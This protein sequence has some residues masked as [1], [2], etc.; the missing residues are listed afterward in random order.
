MQI[1]PFALIA[2]CCCLFLPFFTKASPWVG[3]VDKQL[4]YDLQTLVEWG[5]LD[6]T[7]NT[8]PVPWRGISSQVD[9]LSIDAMPYRPRQAL[10]RLKH[11]LS[12]QKQAKA[13]QYLMLQGASDDVRFR[14]LDDGVDSTGK[15]TLLTELY[16]GPWSA[17]VSVNYS[18][19][20]EKN[21]DNSFLAYQFGNWNLRLGS[22]EQF[23]G[24]AQ[25]SSLILSNNSRP[26]KALA[27]SRSSTAAPEHPWLSWIGSWYFTSQIGQ[28]ER[29]RVVPDTKILLN[30]FTMR[31]FDG[32]ELGAS[33]VLMWGG[34][35][36]DESVDSFV[37]AVTF[38]S[39]CIRPTGIC[40]KSQLTKRGNHI[41]G[42][43]L[44]YTARLFAR[45][46][47]F[48]IQRIGEDSVDGYRITDNANLFGISTYVQGVKV[49][50]ETSDTNVNCDG[51]ATNNLNCFY[52][53]GTY[54]TGYRT[55]GR[56]LGST[57]DSDAKQM[58]AG[59]NFRFEN[60]AVAELLL[61]DVELNRDGVRPSP[62]L[63]D[64]DSENVL[65][66]SGFYQHPYGQ[67]LLKAGGSIARREFSEKTSTDSLI[68]FKAQYAY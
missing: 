16:V 38:Q 47:S 50:V 30:R 29:T 3:T 49:F 63:I 46:V 56:A 42:F 22:I 37:E 59:A 7:V 24:P 58:T 65:E 35:G 27:L 6:T 51:N 2:L 12:I 57:F 14:S 39:V 19:G 4:H 67:W 41:A 33:W 8:Y 31:P 9:N 20:G 15:A 53:N 34:E 5:F 11:Y 61:R 43:D 23:W 55:Y 64:S 18:K 48:Y 21:I 17:Q 10:L 66:L 62:L 25:S 68:Y 60:G 54:Q 1:K 28:L 45:P 52:E 44:S 40:T 36:Q 32:F 13:R 26:I